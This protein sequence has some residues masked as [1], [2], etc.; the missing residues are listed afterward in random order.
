[1]GRRVR[2]TRGHAAAAR[3]SEAVTLTLTLTLILTL[4][5]TLAAYPN[6]ITRDHALL[7][8]HI[9][10]CGGSSF[11]NAL[12]RV[13]VRVRVRARVRVRVRVRGSLP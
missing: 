3:A 8:T 11:R 2:G 10:K 7:F 13:R 12:V 9:P 1:M 6:P 4:T 5:L